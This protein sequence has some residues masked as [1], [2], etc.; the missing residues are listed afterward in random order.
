MPKSHKRLLF[1][2]DK[3]IWLKANVLKGKRVTMAIVL[4]GLC[5]LP[6]Y[7]GDYGNG[8]I[9]RFFVTNR[10]RVF[11]QILFGTKKKSVFLLKDLFKRRLLFCL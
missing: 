11:K 2:L 3:N 9:F 4:S 1:A 8:E 10:C 5:F 6:P 7:A